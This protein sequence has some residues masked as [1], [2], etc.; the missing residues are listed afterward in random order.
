MTI[1]TAHQIADLATRTSHNWLML[2]QDRFGAYSI[3]A[4]QAE[5]TYDANATV[6]AF[7][8]GEVA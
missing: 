6:R 7:F 4:E 5:A 8:E 1:R 2:T 3:E